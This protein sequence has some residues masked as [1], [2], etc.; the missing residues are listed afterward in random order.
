ME[1]TDHDIR[2]LIEESAKG[3]TESCRKLY[4]HLA[5][6]VFAFVRTRTSTREHAVDIMQDVCIDFFSTL[7]NFTY[8]S[9]AQFYAYVFTITRRKLAKYYAD[10]ERRGEK[11]MM[12]FNDEL[13]TD[14][15]PD[16]ASEVQ[17]DVARALMKLD[18]ETRDIVVLHHWSRYTFGEIALL[19]NMTETAV[20]VRHHRALKGLGETLTDV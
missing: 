4:D 13:H 8:Q 15:K 7:S 5:D 10:R 19:M 11:S 12:E 16:L 17:S 1:E 3:D 14:T 6:R 2:N 9:R 20:R 18:T